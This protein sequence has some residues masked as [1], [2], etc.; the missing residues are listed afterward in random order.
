MKEAKDLVDGAPKPVKEGIAKDEAE[1]IKKKLTD[2]GAS[3]EAEVKALSGRR[4]PDEG[5]PAAS[6]YIP[7]VVIYTQGYRESASFDYNQI[8]ND[9]QAGG[10][11]KCRPDL[12][13]CRLSVGKSLS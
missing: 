3:V 9:C 7:V 2:A 5:A 6:L 8:S 4:T 13:L 1:A 11:A 10:W 12:P